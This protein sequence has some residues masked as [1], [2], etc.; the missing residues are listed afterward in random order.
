RAWSQ[1]YFLFLT[2]TGLIDGSDVSQHPLLW[3][4]EGQSA[5]MNCS[6]TKDATFFQMYW[7]RQLPGEGMKQIVFTTPTPPYKYES[8]FSEEKFPAT[9]S[10]ALTGSL[11]VEKLLPEDS[12]V[13]F[14][15]TVTQTAEAYFGGGTKLTVLVKVLPPSTKE[16]R[17]QKDG[18]RKKTIVCVASGFYPDHVSV[19]W[20]IDGIKATSGVATDNAALREGR[21]YRIT[22]RLKVSGEDWFTLYK[23]FTCIVEFFDGTAT[24]PYED[25]VLGVE[26]LFFLVLWE[27][28]NDLI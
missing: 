21:Y 25:T 17:N 27:L 28:R 16:C 26:G 3:R 15:Y 13:Y 23:N 22:S 4:P 5:T 7:Y 1:F 11:T 19:K 20:K 24:I 14:C 6:H 8:G 18:P 10:N 2:L 12:G 9:K